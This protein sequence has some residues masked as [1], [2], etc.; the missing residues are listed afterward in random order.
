MEAFPVRFSA[1]WFGFALFW[2]W[3]DSQRRILLS[4]AWRLWLPTSGS[5][6]TKKA[7][8]L[9][10]QYVAVLFSSLFLVLIAS[11]TP[12]LSFGLCWGAGGALSQCRGKGRRLGSSCLSAVL[13]FS[14]SP[15]FPLPDLSTPKTPW[16]S[17]VCASFSCCQVSTELSHVWAVIH[18]SAFL[19][20]KLCCCCPLSSSLCLTVFI[21]FTVIFVGRG[22]KQCSTYYFNQYAITMFITCFGV[23][24]SHQLLSISKL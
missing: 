10:I 3:S 18:P 24:L 15:S 23:Y 1:G 7:A 19:L 17:V 16:G 11:P 5:Q 2:G 12:I 14:A 20:P 8:D 13:V 6:K 22:R 4:P 9:K 21:P